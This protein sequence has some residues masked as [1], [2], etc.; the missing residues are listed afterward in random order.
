MKHISLIAVLAFALACGGASSDLAPPPPTGP[1][2]G[3][4]TTTAPD[5]V[6]IAYTVAGSG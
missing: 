4:G 2:A 3:P 6:S 1:M 5:G